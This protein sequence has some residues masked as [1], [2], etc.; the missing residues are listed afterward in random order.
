[1]DMPCGCVIG[2]QY[3]PLQ[4][5]DRLVRCPHGEYVINGKRVTGMRFTIVSKTLREMET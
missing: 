1:M 3:L 2:D 5:G 4:G